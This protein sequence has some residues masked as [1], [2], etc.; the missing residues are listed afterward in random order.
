MRAAFVR[1]TSRRVDLNGL[2]QPGRGAAGVAQVWATIESSVT[3]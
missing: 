2:T 3:H 1:A